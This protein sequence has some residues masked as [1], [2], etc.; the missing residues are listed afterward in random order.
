[1]IASLYAASSCITGH[2]YWETPINFLHYVL[3]TAPEYDIVDQFLGDLH[4]LCIITLQNPD[5]EDIEAAARDLW[6]GILIWREFVKCLSRHMGLT[7][8][9][10]ETLEKRG[11]LFWAFIP[12]Y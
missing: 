12:L 6:L 11:M 2:N 8:K 9:K 3:I 1:M 5:W 4:S 7:K 10:T